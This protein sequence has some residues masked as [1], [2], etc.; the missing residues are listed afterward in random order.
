[1]AHDHTLGDGPDLLNYMYVL[2]IARGDG[3]LFDAASLQEED[4]VELCVKVGKPHP[5]S[6]VWLSVM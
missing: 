6:V 1:M 5:K 4:T 3:T 2:A